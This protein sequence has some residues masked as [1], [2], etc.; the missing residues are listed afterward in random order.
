MSLT[1][2]GNEYVHL[3][4]IVEAAEKSHL[5]NGEAAE[6]IRQ[7]IKPGKGTPGYKQY[8][9]IMLMRILATHPGQPFTR[10]LQEERFVMTVKRVLT[11]CRDLGVQ[12]IMRDTLQ[13]LAVEHK[14]DVSLLPLISLW[15]GEKDSVH[16]VYQRAANSFNYANKPAYRPD[17]LRLAGRSLSRGNISRGTSIE[18]GSRS[19]SASPLPPAPELA[20]RIAEA[21]ETAKLLVQF[22]RSTPPEEF[23]KN[24]LIGEFSQRCLSASGSIQTYMNVSNPPPDEDTMLSLI[25]TNDQLSSALSQYRRHATAARKFKPQP[26]R[27]AAPPKPSI[28][29]SFSQPITYTLHMSGAG[30]TSGSAT[31]ADPHAPDHPRRPTLMSRATSFFR[32]RPSSLGNSPGGSDTVIPEDSPAEALH[33]RQRHHLDTSLRNHST[34]DALAGHAPHSSHIHTAPAPP[35]AADANN[36]EKEEG[37]LP[38]ENAST[39]SADVSPVPSTAPSDQQQQ[40]QQ[41]HGL[42]ES[43]RA[44]SVFN[45]HPGDFAV[46]SPFAGEPGTGTHEGPAAGAA[47]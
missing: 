8:N 39:S 2:Q 47:P 5:A 36:K 38:H 23:W 24:D 27:A 9:A 46:H 6:L 41:Q 16:R 30:S 10:Y 20:A 44:A 7:I 17:N 28:V 12:H 45:Y 31:P 13:A 29:R 15:E 19:A 4:A 43:T 37:Q 3:P 42:S 22:V 40:P 1:D 18:G 26:E 34:D 11:E 32:T 33:E 35:V 21:N 14:H 25:D